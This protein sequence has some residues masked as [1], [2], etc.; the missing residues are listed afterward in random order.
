MEEKKA[1]KAPKAKPPEPRL[2]VRLVGHEGESA[3]VEWIIEGMYH[4]VY[5]PLSK[6]KDGTVAVKDL[7]RGIPYGL[8]WEDWIEIEATPESVANEL[9]RQGVWRWQDISN[10]ALDAANRAFNKGVFLRQINQ[11]ANK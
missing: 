6:L 7:E 3:L 10:A 9:R 5:V 1:Q 4:R 2:S 11:E 8:P